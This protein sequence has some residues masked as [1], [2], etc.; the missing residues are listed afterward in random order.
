MIIIT[1]LLTFIY[2]SDSI[3]DDNKD[4]PIS[5]ASESQE[6]QNKKETIK[7]P[8]S[9]EVELKIDNSD[10][11]CDNEDLMLDNKFLNQ[12]FE[13]LNN[14]EDNQEESFLNL[15]SDICVNENSTVNKQ[16]LFDEFETPK[17]NTNTCLKDDLKSPKK[18]SDNDLKLNST[19]DVKKNNTTSKN[20][21][22]SPISI[23][24][25]QVEDPKKFEE[26]Q[27]NEHTLISD[28]KTN[29]TKTNSNFLETVA[30]ISSEKKQLINTILNF[31]KTSIFLSQQQISK[32]N[33]ID[34]SMEQLQSICSRLDSITSVQMEMQKSF[35]SITKE[36][37]EQL[38]FKDS[39]PT[40]TS[41]QTF[42]YLNTK[43]ID[44][45]LDDPSKCI[46]SSFDI[47]QPNSQTC[48]CDSQPTTS[49]CEKKI[50]K[51]VS[52]YTEKCNLP[53]NTDFSTT[54]SK[55]ETNSL[56]K[57]CSIDESNCELI[58]S[59]LESNNKCFQYDTNNSQINNNKAE[60]TQII[61]KKL[62]Q[63]PKIDT[64]S[65]INIE[66]SH[67]LP[68]SK[69]SLF[70]QK[71]GLN[72]ENDNY[73]YNH[74]SFEKKSD[75]E[76]QKRLLSTSLSSALKSNSDIHDFLS[77]K[78]VVHCPKATSFLYITEYNYLKMMWKT[79]NDSNNDFT[80]FPK[81]LSFSPGWNPFKLS[82]LFTCAL[83]DKSDILLSIC[84]H[85]GLSKY[86][87]IIF[88]MVRMNT[89]NKYT[90]N[91]SFNFCFNIVC[92]Y[93]CKV[94]DLGKGKDTEIY[95]YAN[96]KKF[97][98]VE[99]YHLLFKSKEYWKD[100]A[101]IIFEMAR[102]RAN[103]ELGITQSF[104]DECHLYK[105]LLI[106]HKRNPNYIAFIFYVYYAKK[107]SELNFN[108]N[109]ISQSTSKTFKAI[110]KLEKLIII[111][112]E[113]RGLYNYINGILKYYSFTT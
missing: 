10:D 20:L 70:W 2:N 88:N 62:I 3:V 100:K 109:Q 47:S 15:M 84:K 99:N 95:N 25:D 110:K 86:F 112:N 108:L 113:F 50:N 33:T 13:T 87:S 64:E 81:F 45:N 80:E 24:T 41:M 63:N 31:L 59:I 69:M 106:F 56:K 17:S 30:N 42:D 16:L 4:K 60:N 101:A 48:P 78:I 52:E 40:K 29:K 76:L 111:R 105:I 103:I 26:N 75:Q 97:I 51:K 23:E 61:E 54:D 58:E 77:R 21:N 22:K 68:N 18:K 104:F 74:L 14:N 89:Y 46:S 71:I 73:D 1:F 53:T 9:N 83:N 55:N 85:Y 39:T 66:K 79:L 6:N 98:T 93:L 92:H 11:F 37:A 44:E 12:I 82:D 5:S 94:H 36:E 38:K 102:I 27:I 90:R 8:K 28:N 32:L 107:A 65:N 91:L 43:L 34:F 57:P 7:I 67:D 35:F 19:F 49:Y 72:I 96:T